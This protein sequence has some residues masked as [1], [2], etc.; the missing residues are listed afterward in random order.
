MRWVALLLIFPVGCREKPVTQ[1]APIQSVSVTASAPSAVWSAPEPSAWP[2]EP[3]EVLLGLVGRSE[4]RLRYDP[5]LCDSDAGQADRTLKIVLRKGLFQ[6]FS[7]QAESTPVGCFEDKW[8]LEKGDFDF[9]G[10]EDF[11]VPVDTTG[12]YGS[13]TYDVF[14][15]DPKEEEYVEA[16]ELSELTRSHMGMFGVDAKRKRLTAFSKS[17]CCIH[18]E[19][20]FAVKE[21][22][23]VLLH[24]VTTTHDGDKCTEET[25]TTT[26]TVRACKPAQND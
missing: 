17:G 9:D 3:R 21:R 2:D 25:A 7:A 11:A 4:V 19:S 26:R 10:F 20:E 14:L 5:K 8:T 12:P 23:P 6:V 22:A 13:G 15:Y 16:G 18:W 1:P 24:T